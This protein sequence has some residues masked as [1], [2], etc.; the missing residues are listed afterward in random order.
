MGSSSVEGA[1]GSLRNFMIDFHVEHFSREWGS[2]FK[3]IDYSIVGNVMYMLIH[4]IPKSHNFIT[5]LKCSKHRREYS[6]KF[7]EDCMQPYYYDCP[8]RL[9]KR[10]TSTNAEAQEWYGKCRLYREAKKE[11]NGIIELLKKGSRG[12]GIII[13]DLM[14]RKIQYQ[15]VLSNSFLIGTCMEDGKTYRWKFDTILVVELRKLLVEQA[16]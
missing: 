16:A 12:A 13:E 15:R 9:L 6:F 8:E 7:I 11:K 4:S 1:Y 10:A 3:L 14:G 2:N 5:V